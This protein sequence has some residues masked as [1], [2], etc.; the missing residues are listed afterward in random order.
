MKLVVNYGHTLDLDKKRN[1]LV[2]SFE[3]YRPFRIGQYAYFVD[4]IKRLW[5][6]PL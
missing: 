1:L 4:N 3:P 2:D 6:R 5:R